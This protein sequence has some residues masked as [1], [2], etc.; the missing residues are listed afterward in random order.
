MMSCARFWFSGVNS[1]GIWVEFDGRPVSYRHLWV[2]N[3]K[4]NHLWVVVVRITVLGW[5]GEDTNEWLA[6]HSQFSA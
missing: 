2:E 5:K 1:N 4:T 6:V 3:G